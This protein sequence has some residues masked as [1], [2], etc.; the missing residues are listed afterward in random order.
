MLNQEPRRF[1]FGPTDASFG[2]PGM[3]GSL[4]FADPETQIGFGKSSHRAPGFASHLPAVKI[5]VASTRV[6]S[7]MCEAP[8]E[9]V[10]GPEA[11]APGSTP[12][13]T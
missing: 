6:F 2:H 1:A 3:G 10:G 13:C 5:Y 7:L 12:E 8:I 11:P 4:G 9:T